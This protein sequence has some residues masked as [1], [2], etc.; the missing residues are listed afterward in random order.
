[1]KLA[2][3]AGDHAEQRGLAGAV[4][5]TPQR[6]ARFIERALKPGMEWRRPF[7]G[8]TPEVLPWEVADEQIALAATRIDVMLARPQQCPVRTP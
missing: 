3:A 1:M 4:Y 6:I 5:C 7:G 2:L 8:F